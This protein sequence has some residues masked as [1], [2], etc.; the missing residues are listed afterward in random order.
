ML[1]DVAVS[2][3][4]REVPQ[5]KDCGFSLLTA[6]GSI[7]Q[8]MYCMSVRKQHPCQVW[9]S[10]KCGEMTSICLLLEKVVSWDFEEMMK[11]R[12]DAVYY[13][14]DISWSSF[15]WSN[16]ESISK[17][18]GWDLPIWWLARFLHSTALSSL[19]WLA[20]CSFWL[21]ILQCINEMIPTSNSLFM[22][23]LMSFLPNSRKFSYY[24]HRNAVATGVA[25]FRHYRSFAVALPGSGWASTVLAQLPFCLP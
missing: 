9:V 13:M 4:E 22:N 25:I 24:I 11:C 23:A 19:W 2:R 14:I 17:S 12:A 20:A 1:F 10:P 18:Q 5:L 16:I 21:S 6:N 8:W 3:E 7:K 15:R